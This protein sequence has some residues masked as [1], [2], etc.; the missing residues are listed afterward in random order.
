VISCIQQQDALPRSA[1]MTS[2]Q[3]RTIA[4]LLEQSASDI[5]TNPAA[6]RQRLECPDMRPK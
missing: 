6:I 1:A 2:P 3:R 4:R 5:E